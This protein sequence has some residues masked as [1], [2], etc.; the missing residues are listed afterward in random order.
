MLPVADRTIKSRLELGFTAVMAVCSVIVAVGAMR[1]PGKTPPRS[2]EPVAVSNW[3][4]FATGPQRF[5]AAGGRIVITQFSDFQC[6]YCRRLRYAL[7][8]VLARNPDVE[9]VFR[10][11]PIDRIHPHARTAAIAGICAA[12]EGRFREVHDALYAG[13]DSIGKRAWTAW[14][15]DGGVSDTVAFARCLEESGPRET[16]AGDSVAARKLKV[17]GTPT[18]LVNEWRIRGAASVEAIESLIRRLRASSNRAG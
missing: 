9:V 15:V 6:P 4:E 2:T 14:A 1:H 11:L 10:N 13:H 12:R 17:T 7:D 5:G 18:V 3:K 16:L 8:T